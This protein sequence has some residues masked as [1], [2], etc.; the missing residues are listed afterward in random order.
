[1]VSCPYE[2]N[3][4]NVN[5]QNF[6]RSIRSLNHRY[7]LTILFSFEGEQRQSG[8]SLNPLS[9]WLQ[10]S[11]EVFRPVVYTAFAQGFKEFLG[12]ILYNSGEFAALCG[13]S[14]RVEEL[15]HSGCS[16]GNL[17]RFRYECSEDEQSELQITAGT[18][19]HRATAHASDTPARNAAGFTVDNFQADPVA[20]KRWSYDV[21]SCVWDCYTA[22]KEAWRRAVGIVR[23]LLQSDVLV[24]TGLARSD[25]EAVLF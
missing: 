21:D 14:T 24:E 22:K 6:K 15:V 18:T 23:T 4:T 25:K 8:L 7:P 5:T 12:N 11:L 3:I 20:S 16:L 19:Y 1:M 13:V 10:E 9:G 2:I 17:G